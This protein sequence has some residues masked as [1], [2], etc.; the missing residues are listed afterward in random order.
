MNSSSFQSEL[1]GMQNVMLNFAFTL[2]RNSDDARD[3]VQDTMLKAIT[4]ED[5]YTHGENF[6]GWVLTIMRNIF[7]DQYNKMS[8][9]STIHDTTEDSYLLNIASADLIAESPEDSYSTYEIEEAIRHL[10][11]LYRI[12][13][14]MLVSGYKYNEIAEEMGLNISTV[15]NRIFTGRHLLQER[16]SDHR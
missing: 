12:P 4:A 11:K 8:R 9:L 5:K 13:L 15:K 7:I 10:D 6:K 16:L 1:M 2:T 14:V 3:L